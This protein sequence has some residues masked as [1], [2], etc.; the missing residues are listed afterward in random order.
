MEVKIEP[1]WKQLLNGEFEKAYFHELAGFVRSEFENHR[2]YPPG[3]RIFSAS[4]PAGETDRTVLE[5]LWSRPTAEING[6]ADSAAA[7]LVGRART[8]SGRGC[9]C[10]V[11][12]PCQ[13]QAV[14]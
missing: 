6:I 1:S 2:I 4:V 7:P 10:S 12:A 5:Q 14:V 3:S 9:L 8:C 13:S 11:A